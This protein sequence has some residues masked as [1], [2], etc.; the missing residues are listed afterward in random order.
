MNTQEEEQVWIEDEDPDANSDKEDEETDFG[1]NLFSA[2]T[3]P[4]NEFE[5]VHGDVTLRLKG[6]TGVRYPHLLNSTGLTLWKGSESLAE[7]LSS[8]ADLVQDKTVVELGAGTGICGILAHKLGA[9]HVMITDG[10]SDTLRNIRA[11]IDLNVEQDEDNPRLE[12][13][14]LLWGTHVKSFRQKWSRDEGFEIVMG[15]D[16]VYAQPSLEPLFETV[17][18]L[19]SPVP[20]AKFILSYVYRS[21]VTIED[22]FDCAKKHGLQWVDSEDSECVYTFFR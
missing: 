17:V 7:F 21:G 6:I 1:R 20:G 9:N 14:Q 5:K 12:C 16:I 13:K 3:Q 19:L 22:V 18:S 4:Q 2:P 10:D 11:N 15:G 8:H